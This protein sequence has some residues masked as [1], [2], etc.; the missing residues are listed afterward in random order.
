MAK[1]YSLFRIGSNG[2]LVFQ[3]RP[4]CYYN[5]V[6]TEVTEDFT[7]YLNGFVTIKAKAYYPFARSD[8][9]TVNLRDK[10]YADIIANTAVVESNAMLLPTS[11][12][13]SPNITAA[14]NIYLLNPGTERA[15]AGIE[16]AG[17]A[18]SGVKISNITT[19]ETCKFVAL[20]KVATTNQDKYVYT[21]PIN[22]KT[23]MKSAAGSEINFLYHDYGFLSLQPAF[24]AIRGVKIRYT[25]NKNTITVDNVIYDPRSEVPSDVEGHYIDRFIFIE[26]KWYKIS[27]IIDSHQLELT[28]AVK[29]TGMANGTTGKANTTILTLNE[30]LI[31]PVANDMAL[32]RLNF[33]YKP[34]Y[35]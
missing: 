35:A 4:W 6:I 26:D 18:I 3:R 28:A 2:K 22:G 31:Q 15:A 10:N 32:T 8:I 24:P 30:I 29:P 25:V 1:V 13:C 12:S 16:I 7:N 5:V 14:K 27:R 11:I 23:V 34:T 19:G 33:I 21:D 20:T 9:W 17:D